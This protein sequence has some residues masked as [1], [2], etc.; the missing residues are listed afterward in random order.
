MAVEAGPEAAV[1][2][3]KPGGLPFDPANPLAALGNVADGFRAAMF[4][5]SVQRLSGEIGAATLA[6]MITPAGGEVGAAVGQAAAHEAQRLGRASVALNG[7]STMNDLKQIILAMINHEDA[8]A[9]FPSNSFSAAGQP[10][11]SWRVHILPYMGYTALYNQFRKD[12]PWD[13]PHNL[14]LLDQMPDVFRIQ[15]DPWDS[16]TTRFTTFV[17]TGAPFPASGN[18][19]ALGPQSRSVTD[20][21]WNTIAVVQAGRDSAVPWTKPADTPYSSNNPLTPLGDLG[22][23]FFAA[24]FDGSVRRLLSSTTPGALKALITH[25]GGENPTNPPAIVTQQRTYVRQTAADTATNEFGV[26]AFDVAL[27]LKPTT[28]VTI[29]VASAD[30]AIATLSR[31]TLTF[32]PDNWN[33]PQRV[34][35]RAVDNQ[36]FNA[37]RSVGILVS[38]VSRFTALIRDDDLPP[39]LAAD[40][41][42]DGVVDGSDFLGW[43]RSL[44]ATG[45]T[46]S[47]GDADGDGVV[48]AHDLLAWKLTFGA[49][50]LNL[51]Q[52]AV[53]EDSEAA[54]AEHPGIDAWFEGFAAGGGAAARDGS[55]IDEDAKGSGVSNVDREEALGSQPAMLAPQLMLFDFSS[56]YYPLPDER[57]KTA[58]RVH[59]D[60][61]VR[62]SD[63]VFSTLPKSIGVFEPS[64]WNADEDFPFVESIVEDSDANVDAFDAHPFQRSSGL[65]LATLSKYPQGG[66]D[67]R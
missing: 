19:S 47:Q 45:A 21:T 63:L 7:V 13:S 6:A 64:D 65:A 66:H 9:R 34:G 4:D 51:N 1:E 25:N 62:A 60:A 57:V 16:V 61:L 37:D 3:T 43:Q 44:G 22:P 49:P 23:Y 41:T 52:V 12:E 17:G 53:A 36:E 26:E 48:G 2:W 10:L 32:T 35:I 59:A 5:G 18:G 56:L 29:T 39:P 15:D 20:G 28:P 42:G 31:S 11:L 50:P 24:M 30:T 40:F 8:R 55:D 67:R 27:Q 46:K 38:G 54:T 33:V 14:A 58:G